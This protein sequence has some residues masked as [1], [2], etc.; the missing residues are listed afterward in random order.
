MKRCSELGRNSQQRRVI[1]KHVQMRVGTTVGGGGG[2][3]EGAE[4]SRMYLVQTDTR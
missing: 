4:T 3:V 1:L 2:W